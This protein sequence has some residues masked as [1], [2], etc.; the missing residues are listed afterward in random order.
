MGRKC[1]KQV[2]LEL[3]YNVCLSVQIIYRSINQSQRKKSLSYN[4]LKK[5]S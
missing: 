4:I 1:W 2:D 3:I 5:E